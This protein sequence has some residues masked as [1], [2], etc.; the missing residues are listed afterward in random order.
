MAAVLTELRR[1][2]IRA[3]WTFGSGVLLVAA[4]LLLGWGAWVLG[5]AIF[6]P[7]AIAVAQRPQL[8]VVMFSALLP[9]DGMLREFGPSW[10]N[11]WK[12][13]VIL[14]L[15]V[16]TFVCP[17]AARAQVRRKLPSWTIA[18]GALLLLGIASTVLVDRNTALVG[19]RLSFF[20]ALI[21]LTVW[22]CPLSR[23][24]R[25]NLVTVFVTLGIITSIVGLWQQVVGHEYLYSLGY[26]YGDTIRF[27]TG[28]TVR[29]FSTFNLPFPFGF[30]LMLVL[31]IALPM[32]IAEPHRLRS[33]IFF[34]SLPLLASGLLF[35]FV[36]GAMLGLAVGLL[37]LAFHRYKMLVYGIPIVLLAALFIPTG[38]NVSKAIFSAE[39][40]QDRTLSWSDRFDR[41]ADN[42]FGTGIGTTGAAAEKAAKLNF[43]DPDATYVPDN[44]WLKVMFELG[45][46]G[47][48]LFVVMLISMFL[49]ARSVERR[50]SGIDRDF[51]SGAVA[52][53]LAVM[54][55][56]LVATY[57]ELA[58][59]DQLFWL[60]VGAI[61]TIAPDYAAGPP[62]AGEAARALDARA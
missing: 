29:S 56:S 9:F 4:A 31:L 59:M 38:A 14:G 37:Y 50:C 5:L 6:I 51:V 35:S 44:S 54:I 39:S 12:Q 33:K 21:A 58:P 62:V 8:G 27:T 61:A 53:I 23:R 11:P 36:R 25:D 32:S 15:L 3:P 17:L 19:L 45:I 47:L 43:Q 18:F 20:S 30:Y 48:W 52:Q 46:I 57:L 22:R 1:N 49:F 16:L 26:D 28:L 2:P 42:P 41:F 55:A 40:L 24:E 13:A 7:T 60:V 34:I 10:T